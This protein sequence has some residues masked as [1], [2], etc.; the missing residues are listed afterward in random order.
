MAWGTWL[1]GYTTTGTEAAAETA[2]DDGR[3]RPRAVPGAHDSDHGRVRGQAP[4]SSLGECASRARRTL[5]LSRPTTFG[6]KCSPRHLERLA[7]PAVDR[8]LIGPCVDRP[9]A[10]AGANP[11]AP[12][13]SA[14]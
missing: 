6:L 3:K 12:S 1:S 4:L 14:R 13:G 5:R 11:V 9:Y 10:G 2:G 7:A 8:E